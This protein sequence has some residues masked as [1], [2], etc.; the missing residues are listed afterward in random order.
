MAMGSC[1]HLTFQATGLTGFNCK[2]DYKSTAKHAVYSRV[3]PDSSAAAALETTGQPNIMSHYL[4]NASH[5]VED[6]NNHPLHNVGLIVSNLYKNQNDYID[7]HSDQMALS[8]ANVD[9]EKEKEM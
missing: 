5:P 7:W 1:A 4:Q 6:I 3:D 8:S 9:D 2:Y